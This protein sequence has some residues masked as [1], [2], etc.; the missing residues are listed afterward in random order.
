MYCSSKAIWKSGL[1]ED[2]TAVSIVKD[3][4]WWVLK[5]SKLTKS[6]NFDQVKFKTCES[7]SFKQIDFPWFWNQ[8]DCQFYINPLYTVLYF[9][10]CENNDLLHMGKNRKW[11]LI[12]Y[13][14]FD[15]EFISLFIYPEETVS[16]T[17]GL[18]Y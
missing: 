5:Y 9:F 8:W 13:C 1:V 16:Q 17:N 14:W 2:V 10:T 12:L 11:F 6:D 15:Y 7:P 3:S 18:A 4:T